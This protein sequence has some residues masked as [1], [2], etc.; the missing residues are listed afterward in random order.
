MKSNFSG[1]RYKCLICYDFDLCSTC[2]DHSQALL[3]STNASGS[4]SSSSIQDDTLS[5]PSKKSKANKLRASESAVQVVK[6]ATTVQATSSNVQISQ[7]SHLNTH[8]MQCILTRSDH[9]LFYGSG[10]GGGIICDFTIGKERLVEGM[11]VPKYT[12]A[13]Q[14]LT[15]RAASVMNRCFLISYISASFL[16]I[17]FF[18]VTSLFR[19]IFLSLFSY[20]KFLS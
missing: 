17:S 18:L 1:K 16:T 7:S 10:G 3:T 11:P 15:L 19:L 9:E 12:I 14:F 5:K 20:S 13:E 6:P 4:S 2:Y 8:A